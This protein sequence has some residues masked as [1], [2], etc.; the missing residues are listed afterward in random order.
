MIS[1]PT[2]CLNMI[3]KNEAKIIERF[4]NSIISIIDTYC[5]CDTG[6]TDN[7]IEVIKLF[8][9]KIGMDGVVVSEPFKNFQYNRNYAL[10]KCKGL[11]DYILVLD[12]DMIL[13]HTSFDKNIL[14]NGD[15]FNILQGSDDFSYV[16]TRIFKNNGLYKYMGVTHEY[17]S[18][19]PNDKVVVLE[20]N[21]LFISDVGDGGC[22]QNKFERDIQ[23]LTDGI[24]EEPNNERYHFY[25]ANSYY[26]SGRYDEAIEWY[27]KRISLKGWEQEVWYSYYRIGICYKQL[28]RIGDAIKSWLDAYDYFPMRIEN[29]YEIVNY[30]RN[31]SNHKLASLFYSITLKILEIPMDRINF[32][33]L[34]NN[35]YTYN[36]YY[37]YTIFA[38]YLG[39]RN[40]NNEVV[41]VLNN[42]DNNST[43]FCLLRNIKFYKFQL[44]PI[45]VHDFSSS[46]IININSD[47]TAFKSS[48]SCIIINPYCNGIGYMVNSRFVNY[49]IDS[50][51]NYHNCEQ[52][53]ISTNKCLFLTSEFEIVKE[54]EF[55]I[56]FKNERYIGIEDIRIFQDEQQNVLKY[57]G[58]KMHSDNK[59][60]VVMGTYDITKKHLEYKELKSSFN[61]ESCEKN[62]VFVPYK[63]CTHIIYKWHPLQICKINEDTNQ[64]DNVESKQTPLIFSHCRG[65]TCGTMYNN[66][67]WFIVHIVSYETPRHYYHI[68]AVFDSELNLSRY[69]APFTFESVN[70]EYS[71]GLIVEET[72][73]IISYSVMDNSTNMG[74]YDKAYIDALLMY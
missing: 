57:I 15:A 74:V 30:Y 42:C 26:D 6:S 10:S 64:I 62:W 61:N 45:A 18:R 39:I 63:G 72:R 68:I 29:L 34:H 50:S 5:I 17:I 37:E 20:K 43:V 32:L 23:L 19:P 73:V 51:G 22:K 70:I 25:L 56:E 24:L 4:L 40:I 69:S 44:Q 12:A 66:E 2:L 33:F 8:F 53:I 38:Y 55:E 3:V 58:T 59:L 60:G 65:S 1:T 67:I 35:V 28:N 21:V 7:T 71:L 13:K 52:H 41:K 47:D 11:S 27:I 9:E 48:S 36:I 31:N 14:S 49:F 46:K 54:Y 16:N